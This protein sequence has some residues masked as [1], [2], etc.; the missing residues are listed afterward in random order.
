MSRA[1]SFFFDL[2]AVA[3]VGFF[4]WQLALRASWARDVSYLIATSLATEQRRRHE[5]AL[6]AGYLARLAASGV[7]D[8]P[9]LDAAWPAYARGMA[10]GLVVGWLIC[11]PRNYGAEVWGAN[12]GRLVAA[13][14]DL[15]TFPLLGVHPPS[16]K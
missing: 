5:R 6:L 10:W 8:A 14:A 16:R 13:C 7:S 9:P 3:Q 11:P 2:T 12:V 4:D 1:L 15:E